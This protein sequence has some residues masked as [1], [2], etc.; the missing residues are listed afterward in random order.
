MR[1]TRIRTATNQT[2]VLAAL[3]Q[4]LESLDRIRATLGP[5]ETLKRGYA[6]IRD[7][8][9]RLLTRA[10]AIS[11]GSTLAI[12][13]TDGRVSAIAGEGAEPPSSSPSPRKRPARSEKGRT[14][15]GSLF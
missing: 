5:T 2:S 10:D 12:E 11:S 6:V 15:Q 14:G 9:D 7:E 8:N 4:R 3:S 13:F 1:R